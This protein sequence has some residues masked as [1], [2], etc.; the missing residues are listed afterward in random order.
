MRT[1]HYSNRTC[2][3]CGVIFTP[4]SSTQKWCSNCLTKTCDHC[5]NA[6]YFG[7]RTR[8]ATSRFCSKECRIAGLKKEMV[9]TNAANYK[10]GDRCNKIKVACAICK[11]DI[12]REQRQANRWK[13][14][15]CSDKCRGVYQSMY[16]KGENSPKYNRIDV[17]CEWCEKDF[18]TWPS[19][20]DKVRFCSKEC[21]NDWQSF[22]M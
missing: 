13:T 19:T 7:K 18:K 20:K 11:K 4:I 10:N 8:A 6:F 2:D 22:M 21:R 16:R 1:L 5:G 17:I 12:L 9:G 15:I 14:H 3:K